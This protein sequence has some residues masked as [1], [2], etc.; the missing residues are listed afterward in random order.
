MYPI[1]VVIVAFV[2]TAVIMIFVMPAF[3]EVFQQFRGRPSCANAVCH[4][5]ERSFSSNTGG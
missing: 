1:S 5:Y 3:K 4:W 2:V